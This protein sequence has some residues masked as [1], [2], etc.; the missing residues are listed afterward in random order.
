MSAFQLHCLFPCSIDC[1]SYNNYAMYPLVIIM[2]FMVLIREF[3]SV[4]S[5][6]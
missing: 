5:V 1:S 4:D 2:V 6:N 3:C